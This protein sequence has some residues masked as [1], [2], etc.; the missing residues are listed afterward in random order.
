MV[1][2]ALASCALLVLAA[3]VP[4]APAADPLARAI[5]RIL[6]RPAFAA[7]FWGI[8]VRSLTLRPGALRAERREE[9][10]ARL[11]LEARDHGGGARRLRP[12]RAPAHDRRDGRPTR[13]SGAHPG[14]RVPRRPRRP[15]PLGVGSRATTRWRRSRSWRTRC[16]P[17]ACAASKAGWW[18]TR[19]RSP[20]TGADPTGG[21]RTSSWCYG[22]EVSALVLQRQHGGP[23]AGPGRA[24]GRPRAARGEPPLVVLLG[25]LGRRD[26]V[27]GARSATSRSCATPA[28]TASASRAR[29]RSARP[30][31]DE[32]LS[33]TRPDTPPPSS[34][35]CS[36]RR[37][38]GSTGAGGHFIRS[39]A[40]RIPRAR[41]SREPDPGRDA[42]GRQQG[43]PEPACRD[44]AAAPRAADQGRG[45]RGRGPRGG[46]GVPRAAR[47]SRRHLGTRG[48]LGP[49]A[50]RSRLAP[51][52][53]RAARRHGRTPP[54]GPLSRVARGDGR[55]RDAQEP[56]EGDAG[57]RAGSR[58]RRGRCVSS[59][60]SPGTSPGRPGSRSS[61]RSSS[62]TTPCRAATRWPRSTRSPSCSSRRDRWTPH[63]RSIK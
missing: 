26:H 13:R 57:T 56:A 12:R 53:R 17:P 8:E 44:A 60:P 20:E 50:L 15:E 28:R 55:R 61:S 58:P 34:S 47:S 6:D 63:A 52:P 27:R 39:A 48:W 41:R 25:R 36:R 33:R 43:E 37:G 1:R 7:A 35:R 16:A 9:L 42:E 24:R 49:V 59:M 45:E 31:R 11:D 29:C 2:R 19:E 54:G 21:G 3:P 10:P 46:P 51:R 30:G 32:W 18:A 14:R 40:A 38:S 62:T 23:E 5:D 4:A 22:A